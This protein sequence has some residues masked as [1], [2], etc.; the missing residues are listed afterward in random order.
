LTAR[1]LAVIGFHRD[2]GGESEVVVVGNYF[3]A[4]VI[5][6]AYC[7]LGMH[8]GPCY[9]RRTQYAPRDERLYTHPLAQ[10]KGPR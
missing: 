8:R 4:A 10:N 9:R 3:F 1:R 2:L 6:E 5:N 7:T